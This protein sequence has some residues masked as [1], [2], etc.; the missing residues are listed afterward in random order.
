MPKPGP[1]KPVQQWFQERPSPYPW[2]QDALDHVRRLMPAADPYRAWA[3][4][5]FTARSGR[6]NECDLLV[7]VPAGLFLVEIKSHPGELHNKGQTWNFRGK[8]RVRTIKNPL[9]FN[10]AK[11]KDLRSQLQWA[12]RK[13]YRDD[14]MVPR[15]EP[16]VFLSAPDLVSHLD[17]VQRIRVYGRD[18]GASGLDRI[19]QDFLG[20][21]PE[22]SDRR[23]SPEFSRH[24]LPELLKTIG[25]SQSTGHLRFG[26]AWRMEPHPLDAGPSWE[27]RL[28]ERDDGLAKEQGRV[29]IYLV[30]Q[31][32]TEEDRR[33][34]QR[35]AR[36]E[37]QV[38]QGIRHRGIAEAVELRD[39]EAGPAILFRHR[40]HDLRL[41][42]YLDVYGHALTPEERRDMVR[43]LAEAVRH[44]HGRSLY[45]RALAARSVFVSFRG[46]GARPELRIT[47]WQTAA[48]DFDSTATF[49]QSV[50]GS[51]LDAAL[52]GDAAQVYLAPETDQPYSDP[53]DL[54]VFG[55]GAVSYLILTGEPPAP[56]RSE[57][58]ERLRTDGGLHLFAVHDDASDGL[59]DLVH[60]AT[61]ADVVDRLSSAEEFLHLL[62]VAEQAEVA[63]V[64]VTPAVDP[65]DALPGQALDEEWS[66]R[67]VLGTG[68]TARAL[69]VERLVED[70]EDA[71]SVE[72]CVFKVALDEQKA[73]R[74]HAE[75]RV[76]KSVGG[77]AIVRVHGDGL[78][79]VGSRTVL[80]LE[81]AGEQS[82]GA[83]LRASGQ[84][85]YDDLEKFGED[86]FLALDQLDAEQARHRDIKPDNLG[87]QRRK[88]G[89]RQLKLFDFSLAHVPDR[90]VKSGTRDYLDPFLG[91][92][93]RPEFDDHAERY[94]A[95][96]TLHE[97]ASGER[98]E[99]GD[100]RNDPLTNESVGLRL[101][102]E[103][104]YTALRPG[105]TGFFERALHR[106]AEHRFENLRQMKDAWQQVFRDADS[107]RPP[108]TPATVGV[109]G[110]DPE[111]A[112]DRAALAAEP[113]TEL[114]VAGLSPRAVTV[115]AGLGAFT[116]R[117]LLDLQPSV[118]DRARGAGPLVRKELNRRR[119]QWWATL[120][121]KSPKKAVRRPAAEGAGSEPAGVTGILSVDDMAERL[122]PPVGR[123]GSHRESVV[124]LTLGLP[125]EDGGVSPVGSWPVQARIAEHLGINQP[126]VSRHHRAEI[127]R[128]AEADWL[129]SVRS[130][131]VEVVAAFGRVMTAPQ[132]A[133]ELRARHGAED[134]TPERVRAR[135]LAV[136]RAA[137]EAETRE[138]EG[139][140]PR[141]AVHRRGDTV[142]LA[143]ESLAGTDDPSPRELADYAAALGTA[144]EKLSGR[145]PLPGRAEVVRAL[146]TVAAPEG[147]VPLADTRLVSLAAAVAP[148]A[149]RHTP[150]LELYRRDLGLERALRI[151]QAGAGVREGRGLKP[152]ELVAR[153]RARFPELDMVA[154]GRE[155][156]PVVLDDA[157]RAAR[158]ELR[159]DDGKGQFLPVKSAVG[160]PRS[161][162]GSVTRT[163]TSAG[164]LRVARREVES[165]AGQ[166]REQLAERVE[167]GGFLA[168]TV[169]ASRL[170]GT[171]ERVAAEF[172]VQPVSLASVF[173]EKFQQ[174]VTERGLDWGTVLRADAASAPGRV[175]PGLAS[176]VRSVWPLVTEELQARGAAPRT[177]LF[178]HD[179]G[180]VARYWDEGGRS[181]LGALQ[182]SARRPDEGPHGLWLLCP[183]ESRTQEPHLDGRSV[184]AL[185]NDGELAYLEGAFLPEAA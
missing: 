11:S 181:F 18:D 6:V 130:E 65:L 57:L 85:S 67:T 159:Y 127:K 111:V 52:I 2:E 51:A 66:V 99:W 79:E 27:D 146:R 178:L 61:R 166:L 25:I 35:A 128:W 24:R 33:K 36:R 38:L 103:V 5:S 56:R 89:R 26:D 140:E 20:L 142:L 135:S 10:D 74:L 165:P 44:A 22:R 84:L 158:F 40:H 23:L 123:K 114:D 136:V 9:H 163:V 112:R 49:F 19:W 31:G 132:A 155:P 148:D 8:D 45:H 3:T 160:A 169:R 42:H 107:E 17:E 122:T 176:F 177:V 118:I 1:G 39:H 100:G 21:P 167:R 37:Y 139:H 105:L 54:D 82:L 64:P 113:G 121:G 7:A 83:E 94:A 175:K 47:D 86:L 104:F 41:D 50:G 98:P 184:E 96:V 116:V 161:T 32:A 180:L 185:R 119:S 145:E 60:R 69:L 75:E 153:I 152:A 120:R 81:Y 143:A 172:R 77:G 80:P 117:Q 72:E 14:R 102:S 156:T 62:N 16:A 53:G 108:T 174:L 70:A 55:L 168:L 91:S 97:M 170:P 13:L 43:Q 134:D 92:V 15:V 87:V 68:S 138:A 34:T 150:R 149:V 29:R 171:A 4:F 63:R 183:I 151:S 12:A 28:A 182:A 141:L 46:E 30:S 90:D 106:D 78:C 76:L 162:T 129:E 59:D 88:D 95:A 173:L 73:E 109:E 48:R 154:D 131:L 115:A 126:P 101:S 110:E 133:Q 58:L 137:V 144:A 93:R 125:P 147:F 157:L 124:R 179:A 71:I 164:P